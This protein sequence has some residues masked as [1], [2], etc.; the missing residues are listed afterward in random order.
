MDRL[1]EL[2]A[3]AGPLSPRNSISSLDSILLTPISSGPSNLVQSPSLPSPTPSSQT[4]VDFVDSLRPSGLV[5]LREACSTR[6]THIS[7]NAKGY[8]SACGCFI[9]WIAD[10]SFW[11]YEID[12]ED[13]IL[14]SR[15]EFKKGRQYHYGLPDR[16]LVQFHQWNNRPKLECAAISRFYCAVGTPEKLIVFLVPSGKLLGFATFGHSP[17]IRAC[18][19]PGDGEELLVLSTITKPSGVTWLQPSFFATPGF[20]LTASDS[21]DTI[22]QF[23]GTNVLLCWE[24]FVGLIADLRFSTDGSKIIMCTS[25]DNDGLSHLRLLHKNQQGIWVWREGTQRLLVNDQSSGD[26]GIT[27][28]SLYDIATVRFRLTS[29][30]QKC[31]DIVI[32]VQSQAIASANKDWY[33]IRGRQPRESNPRIHR[34]NLQAMD[35]SIAN[36]PGQCL[37]IAVSHKFNAVCV[38]RKLQRR[39][40]RTRG[41]LEYKQICYNP[42]PKLV[43]NDVIIPLE[44]KLVYPVRLSYSDCETRLILINGAVLS[45]LSVLTLGNRESISISAQELTYVFGFWV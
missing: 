8:T 36:A 17:V 25:H 18:F 28:I 32:S 34:F 11:I 35:D 14:R 40:G 6:P 22:R 20:R 23:N 29:S 45:N 24:N 27:G 43:L 7:S 9:V 21:T 38:V 42:L 2:P 1:D 30:F 10:H 37:A 44:C 5:Y 26:V 31:R 33:H 12:L 4:G 13:V 15:G 3:F 16:R 19:S 41:F 39:E